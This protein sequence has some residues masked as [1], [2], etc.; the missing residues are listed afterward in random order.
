MKSIIRLIRSS[1]GGV[2]LIILTLSILSP[3]AS[4]NAYAQTDTGAVAGFT[5]CSFNSKTNSPDQIQKCLSQIFRFVFVLSIFIIAIRVAVIALGNY[6]PFHN[7][8]ADNQAVQV[9]WEVTVGL[10]LI[11]GP[12]LLINVINPASLNLSFLGLGNL[13]PSGVTTSII[14][15]PNGIVTTGGT[16][17]TDSKAPTV[18]GNNA[19][20]VSNAVNNLNDGAPGI[21]DREGNNT[22]GK[23]YQTINS[24][25][26]NGG[27]VQVSAQTDQ[28]KYLI[29]EQ[30]ITTILAISVQCQKPFVT[31]SR[32]SDCRNLESE[33]FVN[34]LA[35]L[36]P[37]LRTSLTLLTDN[38]AIN[39]GALVARTDFIVEDINITPTKTV[40]PNCNDHYAIIRET[41]TQKSWSTITKICNNELSNDKIWTKKD[42]SIVPNTEGEVLSGTEVIGN[43]QIVY[44]K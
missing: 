11:G 8:S 12:V 14:T 20:D 29:S 35:P 17:S 40:N 43:N 9:V 10:I 6:D 21:S 34:A 27:L 13:A 16:S 7:G 15:N 24:I 30:K 44:L 18:E 41:A 3:L 42:G 4:L 37:E 31:S 23:F 5:E 33:E 1:I 38:F 39:E 32:L 22:T 26:K 19:E 28:E 36:K 25:V 2:I